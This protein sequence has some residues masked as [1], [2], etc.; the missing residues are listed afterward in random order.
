[1]ELWENFIA[2]PFGLVPLLL[3]CF[4]AYGFLIFVRGFFGSMK[5]TLTL[6]GHKEHVSHAQVRAVWGVLVMLTAFILWQVY[7]TIAAAVGPV[8]FY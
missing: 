8:L 6:N 4:A 2:N 7:K 1:M 3:A 5:H